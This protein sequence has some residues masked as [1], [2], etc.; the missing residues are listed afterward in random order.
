MVS[1]I[2]FFDNSPVVNLNVVADKNGT[3][4]NKIVNFAIQNNASAVGD[5]HETEYGKKSWKN[6]HH[7]LP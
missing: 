6:K 7:V 2:V 4:S 1:Y 3:L 5:F